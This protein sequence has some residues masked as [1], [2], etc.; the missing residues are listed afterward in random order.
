MDPAD[1][2]AAEAASRIA[3]QGEPPV[4][5]EIA[6]PDARIWAE[7]VD[8]DADLASRA[9]MAACLRLLALVDLL[10]RSRALDH[11]LDLDPRGA[12]LHPRLL[13]AAARL[14]LDAA[15]RFDAERAASMLRNPPGVLA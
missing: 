15:G 14:P 2:P 1:L 13:A 4:I 10:A 12:E 6:D 3:F 9:G 7:A 8:R 5:L 11:L